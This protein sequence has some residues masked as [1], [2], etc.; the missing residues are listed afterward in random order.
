MPRDA[1][2]GWLTR[3]P[4]SASVSVT[5][6]EDVRDVGESCVVDGQ[7]HEQVIYKVCGFIQ[8]FVAVSGHRRE[9]NLAFLTD[10][11]YDPATA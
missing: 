1:W 5:P 7:E 4:R 11:L 3:E 9:R 6:R 8:Q 10:F 2:P